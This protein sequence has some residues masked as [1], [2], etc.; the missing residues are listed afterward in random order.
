M[1]SLQRAAAGGRACLPAVACAFVHLVCSRRIIILIFEVNS[2]G[3][4]LHDTTHS[5]PLASSIQDSLT[6]SLAHS[7][8]HS[9]THS[10]KLC[11]QPIIMHSS[12]YKEF[13]CSASRNKD[14]IS[15]HSSIYHVLKGPPVTHFTGR[16]K[17]PLGYTVDLSEF[18][19]T[20]T[21][22]L[23][24]TTPFLKINIYNIII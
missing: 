19:N 3:L 10:L 17:E 7:L 23:P 2:E 22:T 14:C 20:C 16:F 15:Q 6:L 12:N 21:H 9:L 11:C 18:T 4:T 1:T 24:N 5:T 8:T 13:Q